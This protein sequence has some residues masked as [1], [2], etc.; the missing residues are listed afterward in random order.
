PDRK[1]R[2]LAVAWEEVEEWSKNCRRIHCTR[3]SAAEPR[4]SGDEAFCETSPVPPPRYSE[5]A[6]R[7]HYGL[8]AL[9]PRRG[10]TSG[11]R[12]WKC[13]TAAIFL[14]TAR[15]RALKR[16]LGWRGLL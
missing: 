14:V 12:P 3:G 2:L 8:G 6:L 9:R 7:L 15:S 1:L 10:T 16:W 4:Q 5:V 13:L 11:R